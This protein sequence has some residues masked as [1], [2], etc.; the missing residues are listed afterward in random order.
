MK[1]K[2]KSV[3]KIENPEIIRCFLSLLKKLIINEQKC[4]STYKSY[5]YGRVLTN[6]M[7]E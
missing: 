7:H 1:F 5:S 6:Q 3:F 2:E 4:P